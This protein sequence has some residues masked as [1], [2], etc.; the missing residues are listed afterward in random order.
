MPASTGRRLPSPLTPE[1]VSAGLNAYWGLDR[2]HDPDE[3]I[4]SEVFRAMLLAS[5]ETNRAAFLRPRSIPR[6]RKRSCE[7]R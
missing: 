5:P 6:S 2:E 7:D 1:M 4:V 3:R